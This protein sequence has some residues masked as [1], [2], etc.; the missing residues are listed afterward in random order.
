M[1]ERYKD[2][3][4]VTYDNLVGRSVICRPSKGS[5]FRAIDR[6]E[7]SGD[8]PN[9]WDEF[10]IEI[11]NDFLYVY[12]RVGLYQSYPGHDI[13][14]A[15]YYRN[16]FTKEDD[17]FL[18]L[19]MK[20]DG[21]NEI[22][23]DHYHQCSAKIDIDKLALIYKAAYYFAGTLFNTFDEKVEPRPDIDFFVHTFKTAEE[24]K[25]IDSAWDAENNSEFDLDYLLKR[26]PLFE[27]FDRIVAG[28]PAV[29]N[30]WEDPT[31]K[32]RMSDISKYVFDQIYIKKKDDD[33]TV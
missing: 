10:L 14:E 2:E 13:E 22:T 1:M 24:I 19:F 5:G 6:T 17:A 27:A 4:E 21:C 9:Q 3:P 28:P 30:H 26:S 18:S 15:R 11:G 25:E 29:I 20:W 12:E 16:Q 23:V 31:T 32:T 8:E 33:D 7:D